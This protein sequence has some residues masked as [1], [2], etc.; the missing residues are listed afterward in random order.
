MRKISFG[1]FMLLII[2]LIG[3]SS[4]Q[5]TGG[6][7]LVSV[8]AQ[9]VVR[10]A[11]VKAIKNA[12]LSPLNGN[13]TYVKL[14]G[15]IDT[16]NRGFIDHLARSRAE[17]AGGRLVA[18]NKAQFI[19]EIIVNS[20]GNDQGRSRVPVIS[21]SERTE[22]VVDLDIIIRNIADGT[23][24][25]TQNVRGEAKYQ[26]TSVIGIQGDGVYYVKNSQGKFIEVP[27]P[28]SYK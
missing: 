13:A 5:K 22:G 2:G 9:N 15:F 17:E 10:I 23:R 3:C 16:Q 19:L 28:A 12:D 4:T 7:G 25:S 8:V 26:Q 18:E 11:G 6:S 14:T 27:N 21:R 24:V 1:L 20:A